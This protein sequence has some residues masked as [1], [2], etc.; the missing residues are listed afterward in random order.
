MLVSGMLVQPARNKTIK[1][2][3][4]DRGIRNAVCFLIMGCV[5]FML[6]SADSTRRLTHADIDQAEEC[7]C[8]P[9]QVSAHRPHGN[10]ANLLM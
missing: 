2:P 7:Q 10:L 8:Q 6:C 4:P 3:S 9:D 5:V 1:Q